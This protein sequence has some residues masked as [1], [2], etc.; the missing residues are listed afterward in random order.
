MF[1]FII[2]ATRKCNIIKDTRHRKFVIQLGS[3]ISLYKRPIHDRGVFGICLFY[4]LDKNKNKQR[5]AYSN[6]EVREH[7]T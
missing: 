2:Y 3:H 6:N 7:L 1:F 4:N 5:V